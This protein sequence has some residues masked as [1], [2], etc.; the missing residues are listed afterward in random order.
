MRAGTPSPSSPPGHNNPSIATT[1]RSSIDGIIGILNRTATQLSPTRGT[2]RSMAAARHELAIMA[3]LCH[4]NVVSLV[5]AVVR[6]GRG[7]GVGGGK[8]PL[9]LLELVAGPTPSPGVPPNQP[10]DMHN[11]LHGERAVIVRGGSGRFHTI[12]SAHHPASAKSRL[13]SLNAENYAPIPAGA[14]QNLASGIARALAHLAER[15]VSHLDM[16]PHNILVTRDW[17]PKLCDFGVARFWNRGAPGGVHPPSGGAPGATP[18]HTGAPAY[19]SPEALRGGLA[20]L[21]AQKHGACDVWAFGVILWEL[22]SRKLP[23]AS[24]AGDHAIV[25]AVLCGE[26][27]RWPTAAKHARAYGEAAALSEEVLH[28]WHKISVMCCQES[29]TMRPSAHDLVVALEK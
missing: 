28:V 16:R 22:V 11:V 15:G 7:G 29:P 21:D 10:C 23:H 3:H 18:R 27:P 8:E 24:A 19:Q 1:A 4:P 14:L 20:L 2:R 9:V 12:A 13:S 25:T 6:R 17:T 5:G 26:R